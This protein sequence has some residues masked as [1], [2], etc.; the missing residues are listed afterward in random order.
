MAGDEED[1]WR[2]IFEK[3]GIHVTVELKGLG[4]NP[5]WAKLYAKHA[6]DAAPT[7]QTTRLRRRGGATSKAKCRFDL[8]FVPQAKS[9]RRS[10]RTLPGLNGKENF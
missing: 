10:P 3:M 9:K 1:A 6:I 2:V 7:H 8:S 5:D 4:E